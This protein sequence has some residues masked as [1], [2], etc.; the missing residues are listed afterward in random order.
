MLRDK[1]GEIRAADLAVTVVLIIFIILPIPSL[2][3]MALTGLSLYILLFASGSSSRKRGAIVMLAITIPMLWVPLVFHFFERSILKLD[4]SLVAWVIGSNR[5]GNMVAFSVGPGYVQIA[6]ACSAITNL[7][8]AF[9]CWVGVMQVANRRWSPEDI[10]WGFLVCSSAVA[11]N[12]TR[13]ALM[14]HS[15]E[16]F[17]VLHNQ[18][19]DLTSTIANVLTVIVVVGIS[20]LGARREIFSHA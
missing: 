14:A 1:S 8:L 18:Y 20:V 16:Y 5:T 10:F 12:V 11:V 19:W 4:A 15:R 9:L 13:I 2:S 7:S 3:W 6:P 17:E